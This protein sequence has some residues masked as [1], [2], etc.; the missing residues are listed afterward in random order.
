MCIYGVVSLSLKESDTS[1]KKTGETHGKPICF[2]DGEDSRK[3]SLSHS[4]N[5]DISEN[6]G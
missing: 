3:I 5:S 6:V 2:R 1:P 4:W